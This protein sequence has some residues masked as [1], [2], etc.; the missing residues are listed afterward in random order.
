MNWE[1]LLFR[2]LYL[3]S[4]K[5]CELFKRRYKTAQFQNN[6]II[7]IRD[8]KETVLPPYTYIKGL[9]LEFNGNN[10]TVCIEYPSRIHHSKISFNGD[11][12]QINFGKNAKGVFSFIL[13]YGNNIHLGNNV[14]SEGLYATLYGDSLIIGNNCLFSSGIKVW[15]DGHT[16][17]DAVT[18]E[19]LNP[20]GHTIQI[21]DHVW[22]GQDVVLLKRTNIP[23]NCIIAHSSVVTKAFDKENCIYA[24][25][26]A[27]AVKKGINWNGRSP[28][29]YNPETANP[30][31]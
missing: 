28:V 6:K 5:K 31:F 26:P 27:K 2:T 9:H 23:S 3:L 14:Q 22:I 15:T 18:R 11:N 19:L 10:N 12:N 29:I 24:G 20:P 21:G 13:Y 7:L 8:G 1:K 25:N 16:V 4:A 17:I 30:L